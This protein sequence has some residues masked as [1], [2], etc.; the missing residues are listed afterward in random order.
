MLGVALVSK[1]RFSICSQGVYGS[2]WGGVGSS[3]H[4]PTHVENHDRD[5]GTREAPRAHAAGE[6]AWQEC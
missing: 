4:V 1:A 6:R 5:G 2:A 3:K